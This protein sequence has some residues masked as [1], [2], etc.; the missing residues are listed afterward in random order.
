M[1]KLLT[2]EKIQ[3]FIINALVVVVVMIIVYRVPFLK[4]LVV[5]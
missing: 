3:G 1:S 2:G 5:R 4:S